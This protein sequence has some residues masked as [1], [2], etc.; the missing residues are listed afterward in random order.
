MERY[1]LEEGI[2]VGRKPLPQGDLLLRLVTPRGSLEAVVRKGQRPTGRTGRLSLF[3]HVRFQLYAKGEGLP[4]LTQAELLG[5]LHGLEAPRRFILAAFLAELAYRLASPE[6]APRIYPLLV[7]GLRGI[8]KHEDP[9]LPLVWAGW[10]VAKAGG[11]GP[12]LEGE[13]LR[14]KRGRLGEEGVY[15]GRE[16]V[17]ALKATLRLPGAQAL[18]HLE[19]APL[20]RLFLALKAHAEE[21][22]GPLRSAEAIGV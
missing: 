6:A 9:L 10:R 11:I 8:A 21:A 5:R 7:S 22:L 14:L 1:R 3:H 15:L 4:T 13:G 2:V 12:N 18:P 19:G 16:G 20:N 17:E